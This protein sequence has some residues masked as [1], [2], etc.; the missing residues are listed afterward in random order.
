MGIGSRYI[1]G[2]LMPYCLVETGSAT[3]EGLFDAIKKFFAFAFESTDAAVGV[4]RE[5]AEEDLPGHWAE[6]FGDAV[7]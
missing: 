6:L 1:D 4:G 7:P 5:V 3:G 2:D